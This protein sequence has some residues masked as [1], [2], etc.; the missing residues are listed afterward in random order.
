M[1]GK[2]ERVEALAW[3]VAGFNFVHRKQPANTG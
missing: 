3:N 1:D 2:W